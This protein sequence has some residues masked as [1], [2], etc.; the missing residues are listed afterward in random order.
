MKILR[1]L[2][3]ALGGIVAVIALA[4]VVAWVVLASFDAT[5]IKA[6]VAE[7]VRG[8][9]QR[10]LKI[11]GELQLALWPAIGLKLG[12]ASLSERGSEAVFA[13]VDE[14]QA[15]LGI[16]PL[17]KKELVIKGIGA[18]GLSAT[19][20]RNREGV[21]NIADLIAPD[22]EPAS[23][24]LDI[25]RVRL[26]DTQLAWRDEKSGT[27]L[28][29]EGGKLATGH[30]GED[31]QGRLDLSARLRGEGLDAA[32]D[33]KAGYRVKLAG[34]SVGIEE[35]Q[36]DLSGNALGAQGVKAHITLGKFD[37]DGSANKGMAE[38]L[39]LALQGTLGADTVEARLTAPRIALTDE[40]ARAEPMS[41]ILK[42][43]R[44]AQG[45]HSL[46][47]KLTLEGAR[48]NAAAVSL[49][50]LGVDATAQF[51]GT[52]LR[53]NL[54]SPLMLDLAGPRIELSG[55]SGQVD[56]TDPKKFGKP[57]RLGLA[58]NVSIDLGRKR[59]GGTL[60]LRLDESTTKLS[61]AMPRL[62]P[63]AIEATVDVDQLNIDKYLLP[64]TPPAK[65]VA[66][67]GEA[68][69]LPDFSVLDG[70]DLVARTRVGS[71][72]VARIKAHEVRFDLRHKAGVLEASNVAANLYQGQ[73]SGSLRAVA[74]TREI[75][76]RQ[77]L[78]N[79][80]L[81]PFLKDAFAQDAIE[82]RGSL[83]MEVS[84]RG[85]T[86]QALKQSLEGS[87]KFELRDGAIKGFNLARVLR[88]LK[89]ATQPA[90]G[91]LSRTEKTD[92][93]EITGSLRIQR[94]VARNDDLSAKSPLLRASGAGSV[95]LAANTVDYLA[96]VSV[97]GTT[98]GQGGKELAELRGLT[99]P[100]RIKGALE[101]PSL[102]LD[103]GEMARQAVKGRVEE[104]QEKGRQKLQEKLKGLLGR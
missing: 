94:G 83:S 9:Y 88:D 6:S 2:A 50:R 16:W 92:F 33:A 96:R 71:L 10:E 45:A 57:L 85:A 32:I 49:T 76:L 7:A 70:L 40:E 13:K 99:L 78:G 89:A 98:T 77:N 12:R 65:A 15:E 43:G 81:G 86:L 84:G 35:V 74:G 52:G 79:L 67:T 58:S 80:N 60:N 37:F 95:D 72:Q 59:A 8:K 101:A 39:R 87:A 27:R 62:S 5:A 64:R 53:A 93:S 1:V 63:L 3:F 29:L 31:A 41:L 44:G 30:I 26:E 103:A 19:V 104:V 4:L 61:W 75:A 55:L 91:A 25:A 90:A 21:L 47:A 38:A 56:V 23:V 28:T 22:D 17:F 100:L 97:V 82:G 102:S 18:R 69:T 24:K 14:A 66:A 34:R 20:S 46:D 11:E 51:A 42:S 73:L 36:V 68:E 48:A 54:A